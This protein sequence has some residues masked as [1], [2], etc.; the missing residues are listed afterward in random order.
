MAKKDEVQTAGATSE[1]PVVVIL[2][3][4]R[5][6][7]MIAAA[8]QGLVT[9]SRVD[10]LIIN[11]TA[12]LKHSVAESINGLVTEEQV[13]ELFNEAYSG[14]IGGELLQPVAGIIGEVAAP[15]LPPLDPDWLEGLTFNGVNRSVLKE[16]GQRPKA[17]SKPFSR[18]LTPEDVLSYAVG[19]GSVTLVTADGKKHTVE[20]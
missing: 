15:A 7:E 6:A 2:T 9:E 18:P 17:V 5:V 10:T 4:S 13:K 1:E 20:L 14:M 16:K 19:E 3:E 8:I 11:A 12:A